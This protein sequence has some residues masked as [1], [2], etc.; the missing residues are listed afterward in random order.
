MKNA[1]KIEQKI[2]FPMAYRKELEGS[3]NSVNQ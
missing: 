2:N 1:A 3:K